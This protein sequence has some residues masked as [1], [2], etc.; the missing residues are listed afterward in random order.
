MTTIECSFRRDLFTFLF[1]PSHLCMMFKCLFA[2]LAHIF[3]FIRVGIP[4]HSEVANVTCCV[5]AFVAA[6][7]F[8]AVHMC[9]FGQVGLGKLPFTTHT[10]VLIVTALEPWMAMM[11]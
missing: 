4:M 10:S 5:F 8:S 7:D 2:A 11:F 1:M 3:K 9:M 6:I